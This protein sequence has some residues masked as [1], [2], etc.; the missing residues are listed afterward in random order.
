MQFHF[1][2]VSFLSSS[3]LEHGR[4]L[5][6][7]IALIPLL[8]TYYQTFSHLFRFIANCPLVGLMSVQLIHW[9]ILSICFLL[10]SIQ[11]IQLLISQETVVFSLPTN[12]D[13]LCRSLSSNGQMFFSPCPSTVCCVVFN[14]FWCLNWI[15][16]KTYYLFPHGIHDT[17]FDERLERSSCCTIVHKI[18]ENQ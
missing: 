7:I 15:L 1:F 4:P 10:I 3:T 17:Q 14:L 5:V 18:C 12:N 13:L 16:H 11:I 2:M 9:I 8:N 6:F